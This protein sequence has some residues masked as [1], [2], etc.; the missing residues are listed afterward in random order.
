MVSLWKKCGWLSGD[1]GVLR[2]DSL[3]KTSSAWL[4]QAPEKFLAAV[5]LLWIKGL[6]PTK[7]P[8]GDRIY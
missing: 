3:F 7:I 6:V 1:P 4:C 8:S 2:E 5:V